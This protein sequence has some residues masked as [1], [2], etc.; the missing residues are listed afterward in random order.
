VCKT[1]NNVPNDRGLRS[2]RGSSKKKN[3]R[4]VTVGDASRRKKND[5]GAP[6]VR[7]M[8]RNCERQRFRERG[9]KFG[10][11]SLKT[12]ASDTQKSAADDEQET[13]Q[14]HGRKTTVEVI[15]WP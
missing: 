8:G 7:R 14:G 3:E 10:S 4:K 13:V 6:I 1:L 2:N 15:P 12:S 11:R 5:Q 9:G